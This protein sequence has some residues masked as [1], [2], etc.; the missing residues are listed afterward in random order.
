MSHHL[1]THVRHLLLRANRTTPMTRAVIGLA[2]LCVTSLMITLLG[3]PPVD[4]GAWQILNPVVALLTLTGWGALIHAVIGLPFKH[5]MGFD[6]ERLPDQPDDAAAP[7]PLS[8]ADIVL[9]RTGNILRRIALFLLMA[10]L[11]PI[12]SSVVGDLV[13]A[14]MS[15]VMPTMPIYGLTARSLYALGLLMAAPA[16]WLVIAGVAALGIG[17]N[18]ARQ[19]WPAPAEMQ[20]R[21]D[22]LSKSDVAIANYRNAVRQL[23]RPLINDDLARLGTRLDAIQ[24]RY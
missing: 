12:L 6:P 9:L 20:R 18:C 19:L 4:R 23:D 8:Y 11:A 3:W 7:P 17:V 2:C 15:P 21:L 22:T 13:L 1:L 14:A 16:P 5:P 24:G 10:A